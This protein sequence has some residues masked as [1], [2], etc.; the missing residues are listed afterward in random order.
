[1][2]KQMV[3]FLAA[4][5]ILGMTCLSEVACAAAPVQEAA[6][7]SEDGLKKM[8]PPPMRRPKMSKKEAAVKLQH[9]F[10][11][12]AQS[13]ESYLAAGINYNEL[14]TAYLYA[15]MSG[16]NVDDI[17]DLRESATWGR[18]R[19]LL[20]ITAG[21]YAEKS[22][23]HELER[24][25]ENSV[26]TKAIAEKYVKLGYSLSDIKMA[27]KLAA[28]S[29]Y[30][31]GEILPMKNVVEDWNAV[32]EKIGIPSSEKKI[33]MFRGRGHRS[34]AGF[35]GLHA[36]N[37]TK[38]RAVRIFKADYKFD[39]KQLGALY[40][41]YGYEATEDI[42]LLAY[43]AKTKLEKVEMMRNVYSWERIKYILGLTPQLYFDRCVEYQARRL[44]ERMGIPEK[45]TRKLM[46]QGFAMH[47]VNM[48]YLL[49]KICKKPVEDVIILKTPH[50]TWNDVA[51]KLGISEAECQQIKDKISKDFGRHD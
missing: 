25:Q 40:D 42:C 46:Q 35:A 20:G 32:Q 12:V 36:R 17:S 43:L 22:L 45:V 15:G 30:T 13:A 29:S 10:G 3:C 48:S 2:K 34:G 26:L 9:E 49:A 5:S 14:R 47:H 39:E 21:E 41:K 16:K 23:G 27:A 1:M 6:I 31:L 38:E 4:A 51:K 24:L 44:K 8:P 37:M 11:E 19:Y 50:N 33:P 28:K 7:K 18:V